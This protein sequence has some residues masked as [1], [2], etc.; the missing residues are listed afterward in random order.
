MTTQLDLKKLTKDMSFIDKMKLLLEDI[1]VYAESMGEKNLLT[2]MEKQAFYDNMQKNRQVSE[3]NRIY[4]IYK[5]VNLMMIDVII[6]CQ[7]LIITM[8]ELNNYL[9]SGII[10]GMFEDT[11]DEIIYDLASD[12]YSPEDKEKQEIQNLIDKK[13]V[14][15]MTKYRV[16]LSKFIQQFDY[17][18]P[19]I[20]HKSYFS[21]ELKNDVLEVNPEIQKLFMEAF[22]GAKRLSEAIYEVEHSLTMIGFNCLSDRQ[23]EDFQAKKD[24]LDGFVNLESPLRLLRIYRDNP[25]KKI[26]IT[27]N[28]EPLF[29]ETI[30]DL[31]TKIKLTDNEIEQAKKAVDKAIRVG[32]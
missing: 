7:A 10:K 20:E 32:L 5:V 16:G 19:S 3:Y 27:C 23:K 17:F 2:P 18:T 9:T 25:F 22:I 4:G 15:L 6:N 11:I 21:T 24:L 14:E 12:G 29:L 13:S 8:I 26:N 31:K 1:N 28:A 30:R